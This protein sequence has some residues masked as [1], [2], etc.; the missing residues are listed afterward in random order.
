MFN[1]ITWAGNLNKQNIL[2]RCEL[3]E[4]SLLDY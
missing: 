2:S 1:F 4:L 3:V